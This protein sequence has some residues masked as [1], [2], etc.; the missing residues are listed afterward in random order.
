MRDN[1]GVQV[2]H[3]QVARIVGEAYETACTALN[4]I[5]GFEKCGLWPV[6]HDKVA[7]MFAAAS[8]TDIP[9]D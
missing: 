3:Y 5:Y 9:A 7:N 6:D 8:V 1:P 2:K 4:V